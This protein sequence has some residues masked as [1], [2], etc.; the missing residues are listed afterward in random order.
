M[1]FLIVDKC[2]VIRHS[3]DEHN[4][5]VNRSNFTEIEVEGKLELSYK[6]VPKEENKELIE[7]NGK[8]YDKKLLEERI[9]T[10]P[11]EEV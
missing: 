4:F 7:I 9:A 3:N 1:K 5:N 6:I 8:M 2:K 10:L 11:S